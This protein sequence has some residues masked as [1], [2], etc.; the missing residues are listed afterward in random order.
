MPDDVT[1]RKKRTSYIGSLTRLIKS[2]P[3]HNPVTIQR[4]EI[5]DLLSQVRKLEE[6]FESNYDLLLDVVNS[7]DDMTKLEEDKTNVEDSIGNAVKMIRNLEKDLLL[8]ERAQKLEEIRLQAASNPVPILNTTGSAPGIQKPKLPQLQLPKFNELLEIQAFHL[9]SENSATISNSLS[10]LGIQ[11]KMK[12]PSAPHMGGIWEAAVKSTKFQIS[13]VT[14]KSI[15]TFEEHDTL[16]KEV[17]ACLNSRPICVDPTDP[18]EPRA[19]TPGHFLIGRPLK[20]VPEADVTTEKLHV[21][22]RWQRQQQQKQH[23][24]KR[25]HIE[26]LQHL[27]KRKSGRNPNEISR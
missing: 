24:W 27:Q 1:L 7:Q 3:T 14:G 6:R 12:P 19:I 23:F 2:V 18:D 5:D 25:W 21:L 10:N 22:T 15:M 8:R 17:E 9:R 4:A 26:Y 13:R 11:W 16:L 20:A